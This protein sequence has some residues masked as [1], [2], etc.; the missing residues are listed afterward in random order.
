MALLASLPATRHFFCPTVK[1]VHGVD[2]LVIGRSNDETGV[3]PERVDEL[4]DFMYTAFFKGVTMDFSEFVNTK[5]TAETSE[6]LRWR[7]DR[8]LARKAEESRGASSAG[9][10]TNDAP[11]G[12]PR[13]KGTNKVT[14]LTVTMLPV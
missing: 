14:P 6:E 2:H 8:H 1:R 3:R 13:G 5:A 11:S 10:T 9:A 12:S 4:Q 7:R